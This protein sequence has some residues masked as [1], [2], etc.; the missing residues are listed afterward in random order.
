MK[1][2]IICLPEGWQ[3]TNEKPGP[4]V[5]DRASIVLEVDTIYGEV[6]NAGF[7]VLKDSES[8]AKGKVNI[9]RPQL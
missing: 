8:S 5:L 1:L 7:F 6:D 2:H 4:Q 9:M 3:C